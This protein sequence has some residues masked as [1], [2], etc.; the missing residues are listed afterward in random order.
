MILSAHT[1][2]EWLSLSFVD[3][4]PWL[5]PRGL[6]Y[7][8]GIFIYKIL[9][10]FK[11]VSW[12]GGTAFSLPFPSVFFSLIQWRSHTSGARKYRTF[13]VCDFSVIYGWNLAD[14]PI[15]SSSRL[16]QALIVVQTNP[17]HNMHI[18]STLF[19]TYLLRPVPSDVQLFIQAVHIMKFVDCRADLVGQLSRDG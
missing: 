8:C 15:F 7:C 10:G 12:R 13:L 3:R 1:T 18:T 19:L 2:C 9:S 17:A 16:S 14:V 5:P 11:C 4:T 6:S